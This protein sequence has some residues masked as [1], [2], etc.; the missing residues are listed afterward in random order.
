MTVHARVQGQTPAPRAARASSIPPEINR[1]WTPTGE[2]DYRPRI[3]CED[4][5]APNRL[6]HLARL[7]DPPRRGSAS[8]VVMDQPKADAPLPT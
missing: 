8:R 6:I 5:A 7:A 3:V 4:L 1:A 2:A